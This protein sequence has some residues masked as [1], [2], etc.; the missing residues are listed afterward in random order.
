M[1]GFYRLIKIFCNSVQ[2]TGNHISGTTP[3]RFFACFFLSFFCPI[4]ACPLFLARFFGLPIFRKIRFLSW[5]RLMSLQYFFSPSSLCVFPHKFSASLQA[6]YRFLDVI[7][8]CILFVDLLFLHSCIRL[9][10]PHPFIPT[11]LYRHWLSPSA[12][13]PVRITFKAYFSSPSLF[14]CPIIFPFSKVRYFACP[15]KFYL[16]LPQTLY[17]LFRPRKLN[18]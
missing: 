13:F 5:T 10:P 15:K 2:E 18:Q 9:F 14:L 12:G 3:F 16:P 8:A 11:S 17:F 6:L 1:S 7:S 4:F